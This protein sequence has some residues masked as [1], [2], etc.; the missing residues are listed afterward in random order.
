MPIPIATALRSQGVWVGTLGSFAVAWGS[1][2]PEFSPSAYGWPSELINAIGESAPQPV[3]RILIVLGV[4]ALTWAWWHIRPTRDRAP[5]H[6]GTA[7]L[8]WSLPLLL[9]PPVLSPD[10]VLYADLGWTLHAGHNPYEVGL[11]T[12]G[13]PFAAWVDPLWA[14][15]GVAYPPLSLHLNQLIVTATGL[16][17]YWSVIAMRIPAV[18]A[19]V[20][21]VVLVPR[22]AKLLVRPARGAVWLGVLNP[23]LLL[24]FIGAAHNDAPMVA[25]SLAAVWVVCRWPKWWASFLVGPAVV[26]LAMAFKQQGGLTVIAV[27]GLPVAA[28]L[29]A[30]PMARRLWLLGWRTALATAVTLVVF[31]GV[32]LASGL[33]FGWVEWLD[34]MGLAGTPAPLALLSKGGALI[35]Q[36]AGGSYTGF[37]IVAG[38]VG[39]AILLA[40]LVWLGVRF[41]NR[42]LALVAW[43]SL[44]IAVL[45]QALHPWYLPWSLAL[46]GL[47][48]LNRRQR[49]WVF[50]FAIAF[51]IWNAL[52]TVIW[53][54]QV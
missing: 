54:G 34:L 47:I 14:G 27:A 11:A 1:C 44:V 28:A 8:L 42:P 7:M 15:S 46:L 9:V 29:V 13:G 5:V 48:P 37:L 52:Q 22:I 33:G 25:L 10:A 30:A 6:A 23:L 2:H 40:V 16:H 35:W 21:M 36:A 38:R 24:H 19:V 45:G 4:I 53:H 39:T 41:A 18:V 26:A 3:N 49:Y 43:A 17:P 20:A 32:S 51:C 50:G 12:S 31:A